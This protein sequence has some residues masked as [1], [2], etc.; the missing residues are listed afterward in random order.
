LTYDVSNNITGRIAAIIDYNYITVHKKCG[1]FGF[2]ECLNDIKVAKTLFLAVKS[3]L[4]CKG[5]DKMIGP[6][7]PSINNNCGFL[8]Y[9][10]NLPPV[11][12]MPYNPKYYITLAENSGLIKIK[13]L[14]AY[15]LDLVKINKNLKNI[16]FKIYN[17]LPNLRLR[18]VTK[19]TFV[20]DIKDLMEI[21]NDAWKDNWGFVPWT[22]EEFN[23]LANKLKMI[24]DPK[25]VFIVSI[26]GEP[27]GML[28]AI[29]DYNII[30]KKLNGKLFPLGFIKALIYKKHINY[31][32]IMIMGIKKKYRFKG[33][34]AIMYEAGLRNALK[35]GY[36]YC[37]LS[38]ILNDNIMVQRTINMMGGQLVKKYKIYQS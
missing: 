23:L 14:Y 4:N 2:F 12:M 16:V 22:D 3:W 8:S 32:R 5:I 20:N 13:E 7:N 24:M 17:K 10:F 19:K 38:W 25:L 21:Y 11:L 36:K 31:L 6:M 28:I 29:P 26:S 34:E 27:A 9:G 37:E 35:I 30:L 1:F 15:N 33:I 18:N